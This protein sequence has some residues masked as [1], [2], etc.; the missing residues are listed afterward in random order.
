MKLLQETIDKKCSL[1]NQQAK[2]TTP[3]KQSVVSQKQSVVYTSLQI[4]KLNLKSLRIERLHIDVYTG[5][6]QTQSYIQSS[7]KPLRKSTKQSNLDH[8]Q[9]NQESDIEPF[10]KHTSLGQHTILRLL[11]L[12]PSRTHS[13][14]QQTHRMFLHRYKDYTCYRS[15]FEIN[16]REILSHTL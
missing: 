6:L 1:S 14:S 5:S 2:T 3:E 10:K 7:Q 15:K 8:L 12:I 13:Q 4:L 9:H 16:T 11:I